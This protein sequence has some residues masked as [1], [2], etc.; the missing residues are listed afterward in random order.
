MSQNNRQLVEQLVHRSLLYTVRPVKKRG[1]AFVVHTST[2]HKTHNGTGKANKARFVPDMQDA[3]S[4]HSL[5]KLHFDFVW[6]QQIRSSFSAFQS[7][8]SIL[9]HKDQGAGTCGP[10]SA[11]HLFTPHHT[12]HLCFLRLRER[13]LKKKLFRH[14]SGPG[15]GR[16]SL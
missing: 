3:E 7:N 5:P 11:S 6:K 8:S 12:S 4:G 9:Q 14:V 10:L 1:H 13:E 15:V 16:V 2:F